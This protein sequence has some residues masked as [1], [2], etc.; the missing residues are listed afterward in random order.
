MQS[1]RN[2]LALRLTVWF[3][4]LSFLPL[5]VITVF[6]RRNVADAFV[7]LEAHY[8]GKQARALAAATS[9][10]GDGDEDTTQALLAATTDG[11][12]VAFIVDENGTYVAHSDKDQMAD[13]AYDDFS[14]DVVE[15]FL[16]GGDGTMVEMETGRVIGY[17]VVP[18]HG[19]SGPKNIAVVVTDQSAMSRL[20]AD[21]ER[22]SF[23]Q[24]AV[25]LA[26]V[27]IAGGAAIWVVV[28]SPIRQLTRVAEQI[29]AGNLEV[30]V[31]PDDMEDELKVLASSFNQMTRQ[32]RELVG[33]L[34]EH[35]AELRRAEEALAR[36][37][38]ELRAT[39]YGIG[40]AV[41]ATDTEGHVVRMNPVAE[42]L[43]GWT[44]AEAANRPLDEVFHI[45]SQETR[46]P[47]EN[48]V[49]RVLRKGTVVGLTNHT[50]LISKDGKEIPIA[51]SGAPI[52]DPQG[53]AIGV[54]LVFRD[55]TEE[56]LTQRLVETR[57]SLIEYAA[58]HTLDELMTQ[59]LDEV[60]A[61]VDSPI[62]FYHFV[63]PDQKTL[64]LQQWSTRT[65]AE[66][67]QAEGKGMHYGIDQ[68]GVWVDC[69][70]ERKP[71]IHNDYASLPH[72]KG[73]P[74]GHAEV[75]RELVVPVMRED[76]VVAI[77]GV[78]NKPTE[79]TQKDVEI[80]SYLADVTWEIV[81]QKRAE[82][83][84]REGEE[85]FRKIFEEGPLGMAILS[86]DDHFIR[87]NAALYRMVGY[88]EE[89]LIGSTYLDITH[90]ED[91]DIGKQQAQQLL[92]GEL[93][94]L[95]TEKRY[96]TKEGQTLWINLTAS[97]IHDDEG[98][99]LYKLT[100][101][102]N[103]T[104][105]KRA[106][107]EHERLTARVR[108]QAR[109]MT[110]VLATVPAGVLLLDAKGRILQ[111]NPKAEKDVTALTDARESDAL[112][113][114]GNRPL[115]E[116]LTSPPTRGLWHEVKVDGR[117]FE[118]IARPVEHGSKPE[119]WVLVI[120]DVNQERE[121]QAQLQ[122]QERLAAVGQLAAG[123]AHDFNNI[124][125]S[126]VLYAQ[127]VARSPE[128]PECDQERM[129]VINQQAWHASQL[130]QQILDFSRRAVLERRSLDVLSLLKE[131]VKLLERT[132]PEHIRTELNYGQDEY[133][134]QADPT[135]VQQMVT[136]LAVNAR[137]VMPSGGTLR[138]GLERITVE[139]RKSPILPE[140]EA[141]KRIRLTV[142]DTG[143][144]I[145]P[146]VLPHIFEPFF[147]TK[148]PGEGSGLGLAQ[149]HG[150]VGQHGGRIDV[151]T[152]VGEGTT[153]SS[154][155]RLAQALAD[156]LLG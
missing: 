78:G 139:P 3:L 100:M 110:Q 150:I 33:G 53:N 155:E 57:L 144:G 80:V 29:G 54:V 121:I 5:A 21:M 141:G 142:S 145:P 15:Q 38:A 147:T 4:L 64:S 122:Q 102:E 94:Y 113:H 58:N 107:A 127:M 125:A 13:S 151:E 72:K 89:E 77:L 70:Y 73:M 41:I 93:P 37:E 14:S 101:I 106:Q 69:V 71:V 149:V 20:M 12:D 108:E 123:I 8:H 115:A 117:I 65:L 98:S 83:A 74:E 7:E 66:F 35:V 68:A 97:I 156:A 36:E 42:Q 59:A 154:L 84:L 32:L 49:V 120:S 87:A 82:A 99:P 45:V 63:E 104:E 67:C 55:Q 85:R 137:D 61:F 114:L 140:M 132:L 48:P 31:N 153:F 2:S 25:S 135:H 23:V 19:V 119:H 18:G 112:T 39:L 103:I 47:V 118:V 143:T 105:R 9:L 40:D 34:E 111:A 27:S 46:H 136:N 133:T 148:E 44:E 96:T 6:V 22:I 129:A 90:P 88:T 76:K 1:L 126:I 91:V 50:L 75:I 24:L 11:C 146:D 128:L 86:P 109:Q 134:V 124:M 52:S 56:R 43:T 130:I 95:Q 62:G 16:T 60:G 138:I 81:R 116:L 26:I 30:E 131:H 79:Y 10:L 28:G 92:S 51:D 152:Q 17:S